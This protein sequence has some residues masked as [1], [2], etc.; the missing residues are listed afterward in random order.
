MNRESDN[1]HIGLWIAV[2]ALAAI[3]AYPLSIGPVLWVEMNLDV[4]DWLTS[5]FEMLYMP[6]EFVIG[7]GPD[8]LSELFEWYLELWDVFDVHV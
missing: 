2:F 6:L 8:W 3:L 1:R 5:G 7:N 4:P